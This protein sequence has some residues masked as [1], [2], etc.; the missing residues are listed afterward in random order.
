M[1]FS[2]GASG[3]TRP[4]I[5]WVVS[6][7]NTASYVGVYGD[8][9]ARTPRIDALARDGI[10]FTRAF[11]P[12]PVCAPT[13][14]T[15]IT[16]VYASSLGTQHMRSQQPLPKEVKFFP[17]YLRATGYFTSNRSKTDYNTST[18][19]KAAWNENGANAHWRHREPGQ[20]FFAIFNFEQSHEGRQHKR[21][22]LITDPAKVRVPAYLPDTPT[23][24]ADLAQY[25][26]SLSR[27]DAAI[28][29]VLDE[30]TA[31]GLA[32]DTIIFYYSDHGGATPRSKRFLYENG[33]NAAFI[34]RFPK[35]YAHLAPAPAGSRSAE[36]INFVDLPPTVLSLAGIPI[37]EYFQ[38][39]AFA[40]A[41]RATDPNYTYMF[42]DR[43]DER[44]DLSRAV[45]DGRWRYIR[46]YLPHL[47][48][49]QHLNY[50]WSQASMAEWA[51]L[52]RAG[53]LDATQRA[54][55]EARAPEELYDCAADPD[56]V[57][58][59]AADAKHAATLGRLRAANRAHLLRI[60][61]TGFMPE[62]MMTMLAAGGSPALVARDD[63]RYPLAR[64]LDLI[65]G[66][67]LASAAPAASVAGARQDP[68]SVVRYWTVAATL[69]SPRAVPAKELFKDADPSVRVAAAT[70][71]L[72][73]D[74]QAAAVTVL[75]DALNANQPMGVRL[76]AL[77]SLSF[78]PSVPD[79]IRPLLVKLADTEDKTDYLAR[80]AITLLN[81]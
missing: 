40:G 56:N 42:R 52:N 3:P 49:G 4:N 41:L 60:R 7:D 78:L 68:L 72:R 35:K 44:Y 48:A 1:A 74:H 31:D 29:K 23:V 69:G 14:S 67:Q 76:A 62:G 28:G 24:R 36:L 32:E 18:P 12:A 20:P 80:V 26:D 54:F 77:N 71:E 45:T 39:R 2:A 79:A 22:K 34:A 61:D 43:M 55:F 8:P 66:L 30:L 70:A 81:P 9:L 21:D 47:P 64:L 37:P 10:V 5:L 57:R 65:D 50:L 15:I 63:A 58:N 38:G 19:F 75:A 53:K 33:T 25:Y 73:G 51:S 11:A 59:L 27:A 6:E 46:N 13:R 17:E 16:G